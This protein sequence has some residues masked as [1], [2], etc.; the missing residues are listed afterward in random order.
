MVQSRLLCT[1]PNIAHY[2]F[3]ASDSE[4]AST[5]CGS[6]KQFAQAEQIHG[7]DIAIA[8]DVESFKGVDGLVTRRSLFLGVRTAD[9]LPVLFVDRKTGMTG[10]VHAGWKGLAQGI[11]EEAVRKMNALG[12]LSSDLFA[13]IG[14]HIGPCCYSVEAQRVA[15]FQSLMK[16]SNRFAMQ[17]KESWYLDLAAVA[18]F[19]L[20]THGMDPAHIDVLPYCTYCDG[21]FFS[22][23]RDKAHV[24]H[25]ISVIGR[26]L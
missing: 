6:T 23:R 12:A 7:K 26:I 18:K 15:I 25:L 17:K 5:Y 14:P 2:F 22:F 13:A 8:G 21:R 24:G 4:S 10:A 1:L 3:D 11:L 16:T 19:F 9:C 20:L